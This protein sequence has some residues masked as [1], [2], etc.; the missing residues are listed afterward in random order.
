MKKLKVDTVFCGVPMTLVGQ[1]Y[2]KST[3]R[4]PKS[5]EVEL[6][7]VVI[8]DVSIAPLIN[9]DDWCILEDR[10]LEAANDDWRGCVDEHA[11]R[12]RDER[13]FG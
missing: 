10:F 3:R 8:D 7:D 2:N 6:L 1:D 12:L 9:E 5:E 4:P 13:R 11:D